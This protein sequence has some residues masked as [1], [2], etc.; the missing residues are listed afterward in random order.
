MFSVL[1][2][3]LKSFTGVPLYVTKLKKH[4]TIRIQLYEG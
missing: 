2:N 3:E 1:E 4:V